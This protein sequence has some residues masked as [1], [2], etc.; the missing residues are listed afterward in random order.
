[1]RSTFLVDVAVVFDPPA[2]RL[3]GLPVGDVKRA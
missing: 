2:M 3:V 1:M